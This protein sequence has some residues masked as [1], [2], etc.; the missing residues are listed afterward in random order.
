M[1]EIFLSY[2]RRDS[3]NATGRIHGHLE[4]YFGKGRVFRDIDGIPGGMHFPALLESAITRCKVVIAVIGAEWLTAKN[5]LGEQG[6]EVKRRLD[7]PN[8]YVRKEI[9]MGLKSVPV[10]PVLVSHAS[11]PKRDELPEELKRLASLNA[12]YAPPDQHFRANI[13]V[14]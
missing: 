8:D 3:Q 7:D 6:N 4:V 9:A 14:L 11:M 1:D 12:I 2:R 13:K 10:I 5:D